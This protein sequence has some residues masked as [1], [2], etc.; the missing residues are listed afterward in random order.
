MS[1]EP[2]L[3]SLDSPDR[4]LIYHATEHKNWVFA[5]DMSVGKVWMFSKKKMNGRGR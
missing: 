2:E 5:L 3:L 4:I 1:I